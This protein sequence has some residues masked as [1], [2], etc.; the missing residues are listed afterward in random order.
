MGQMTGRDPY[1]EDGDLRMHGKDR[2][3]QG[4]QKAKI[5]KIF[6]LPMCVRFAGYPKGNSPV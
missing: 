6:A 3:C 1:L 2:R 5:G 4:S